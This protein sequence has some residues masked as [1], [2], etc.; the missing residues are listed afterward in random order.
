[1]HA[2][3]YHLAQL[4]LSL[5]TASQMPLTRLQ[6]LSNDLVMVS[7]LVSFLCYPLR[8]YFCICTL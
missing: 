7:K 1:M 2:D 3:R 4:L 6:T 8:N 5:S